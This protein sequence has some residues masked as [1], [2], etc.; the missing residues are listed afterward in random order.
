MFFAVDKDDKRIYIKNH[1]LIQDTYYR[2]GEYHPDLENHT[3]RTVSEGVLDLILGS[4]APS[5]YDAASILETK[6]SSGIPVYQYQ[7]TFNAVPSDY[8]A[9]LHNGWPFSVTQLIPGYMQN[10]VSQEESLELMLVCF[11]PAFR[12]RKNTCQRSKR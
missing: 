3:I 4:S 2:F 7:S 5:D 10:Q 6:S 9:A 12:R 11:E 8:L 1:T